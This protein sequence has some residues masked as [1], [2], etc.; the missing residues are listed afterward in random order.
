MAAEHTNRQQTNTINNNEK[1]IN[2][3]T[4][5]HAGGHDARAHHDL[6]NGVGRVNG[7]LR[8]QKFSQKLNLFSK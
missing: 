8:K 6:R 3:Q 7:V 2:T 4:Q 5:P 1:Y